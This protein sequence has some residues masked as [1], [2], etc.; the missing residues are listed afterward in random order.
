M[1]DFTLYLGL[2]LVSLGA[3]TI[4]PLQSEWFV[5]GLILN[6][7]HRW[8][9]VVAIASIGNILG[10]AVNYLLGRF[11]AQ[12][13]DRSWFPASREKM[14]SAHVWYRRYGRFSLLLS[15]VPIIGDPL[16]IVAGVLRESPLVF[17]VIVS[18][19]KIGRYLL[20]TAFTL[21]WMGA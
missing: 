3:A 12:L 1:G 7:D 2:F 13:Q 5:V 19:A 18:I 9:L 16:T 15:W 11:I 8:E 17:A 21:N 4:L 10:S 6:G 14:Q 20:L